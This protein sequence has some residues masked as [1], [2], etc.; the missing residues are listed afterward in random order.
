M[1]Y[2]YSAD[3]PKNIEIFSLPRDVLDKVNR[4]FSFSAKE[5]GSS[6]IFIHSYSRRSIEWRQS[7]FKRRASYVPNL[8]Q[9]R[10]TLNHV[11]ARIPF[12]TSKAMFTLLRFRF[13]PFLLMKTLHVHI[14]PFSNEYAV[15][16]IGVHIA[17]AKW[18]C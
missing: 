2:C 18:C 6:V 14:A 12:Q 15:K 17:P 3:H 8:T 16:T 5:T 11:L 10:A 7:W 1:L 9:S 13:Y 4:P